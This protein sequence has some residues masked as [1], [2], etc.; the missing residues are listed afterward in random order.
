M[1]IHTNISLPP[2][3][4]SST[5]YIRF[6]CFIA[7]FSSSAFWSSFCVSAFYDGV[8]VQGVDTLCFIN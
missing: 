8:G 7:L 2:C 4:V 1:E 5:V 3:H 6:L